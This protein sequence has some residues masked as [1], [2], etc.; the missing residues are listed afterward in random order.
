MA[1]ATAFRLKYFS[2]HM[3]ISISALTILMILILTQWYPRYLFWTEGAY[4]ALATLIGVDIVLG[5]ALTLVVAKESK[6]KRE[7]LM[8]LS[9]IA[10]FQI[11]A[12]GY[13]SYVLFAERPIVLPVAGRF[14][15]RTMTFLETKG[16]TMQRFADFP[17]ETPYYAAL[18]KPE[19]NEERG[20]FM[21]NVMSGDEIGTTEL[22]VP[23]EDNFQIALG[24]DALDL[25]EVWKIYPGTKAPIEAFIAKHPQQ[26]LH[27][28]GHKG[29][30]KNGV[31]AFDAQA[32]Y[33][34]F[35]YLDVAPAQGYLQSNPATNPAQA[36]PG[37]P[38]T[39]TTEPPATDATNSDQ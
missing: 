28:F 16:L 23:F 30:M 25:E 14:E 33:V 2:G 36:N 20:Q 19:T 32:Q 11:A 9:L 13:G 6:P 8:D 1:N 27:F 29:Q 31:V 17:G 38:P 24:K 7:L 4:F 35:V 15:A 12:F 5:P 22:Y 26:T 10:A 21:T 37:A 34:G 3:A 18:R 39:L